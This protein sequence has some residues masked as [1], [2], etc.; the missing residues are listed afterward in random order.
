MDAA[1]PVNVV[2][3]PVPPIDPGFM[4]QFPAGK[5]LNATLAVVVPHVGCVIVPI[6]GVVAV[7]TAVVVTSALAAE[8][9]PVAVSVT[10]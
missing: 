1:S 3:V 10:V 2:V 4:V 8:V 6:T 7:G 9:Q 5:L